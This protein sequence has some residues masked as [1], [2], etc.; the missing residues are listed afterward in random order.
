MSDTASAGVQPVGRPSAARIVTEVTSPALVNTVVPIIIGLH[1]GSVLWG[2]LVSLC[3]GLVPF[4]GIV[5]GMRARRLSDHHVT[6]RS[7]RPLVLVS[8]LV[9]LTAG[10]AVELA[11]HAPPDIV[12]VIAAMLATLIALALVTVSL[13]WKI[14][15]HAAVASG[16]AMMLGQALGAWW[17]LTL[18]A[19]PV[20]MWSR[21][22]VEEHSGRQ[23]YLGAVTGL[24]VA[25]V[26]F[27]LVR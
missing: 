5:A 23:V 2:V 12:A 15:V 19:V 7:Q 9:L 26:T 17:F 4:M 25:G 21:V 11:G 16:S 18:L 27:A 3:S 22:Q 10:F 20:V 6:D 24:V 13:R 1:A 14:S 8:I